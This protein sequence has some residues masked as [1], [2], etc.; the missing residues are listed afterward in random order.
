M[1]NPNLLTRRIALK[2][3]A[4]L[5]GGTLTASQLGLLTGTVA[6]MSEDAA[7]RFLNEDRFLMLK[8]VAR[9]TICPTCSLPTAPR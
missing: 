7:P 8:Q 4:A 5:F 2:R 9:R 3:A 1:D 6:A